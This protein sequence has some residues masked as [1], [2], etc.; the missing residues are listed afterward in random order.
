MVMRLPAAVG[1]VSPKAVV[2]SAQEPPRWCLL[3]LTDFI[4]VVLTDRPPDFGTPAGS[5]SQLETT[6]YEMSTKPKP[7]CVRLVR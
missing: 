7:A 1:G 2:S 5:P 4:N 3:C 6:H